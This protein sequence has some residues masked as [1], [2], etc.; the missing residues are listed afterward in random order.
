MTKSPERPTRRRP[1]PRRGPE[2]LADQSFLAYARP[3]PRP[4]SRFVSGHFPCGTI[5]PPHS[6]GCI[7]L[8]GCLQGPLTMVTDHERLILDT[9]AFYVLAPHTR[10]HWHNE[11]KQTAATMA[12]L[13]ET[14]RTSGW[15]A[16]S[17]VKDCC[18]KLE[19]LVTGCHRF[20]TAGDAELHHSFWLAADHLTAV[21]PREPA[22]TTGALLTLLGQVVAR[23]DAAS[24]SPAAPPD[25]VAQQVRLLLLSRV[26]DRLSIRDV[27]N[28]LVVSPTKAKESF[29]KAFGCGI[30][31]YHNQ[32]KIWQ[33][34]RFLAD[35]S[36]SIEQ[37]SR[38]LGFSTH[39]YFS[40]VFLEHTGERPTAY[41][42]RM[43]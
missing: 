29:R 14:G 15:P 23:L 13:I 38:K 25:D 30:M 31:A 1:A 42:N 39:S 21:T 26:N 19:A 12:F 27:A 2:P 22:A 5:S 9:G 34:K 20:S 7:A 17:G 16:S 18:R 4:F 41:R 43:L 35:P 36:L 28:E 32:L 24:A 11:G 33:A 3:A 40:Q 10:H 37:I 6:H 8:H